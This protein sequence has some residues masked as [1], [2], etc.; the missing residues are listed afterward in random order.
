MATITTDTFL[1]D[2]TART[3]GEA[4]TLNGAKLTVRTDTR[5]HV[6]APAG[7]LGALT[8]VICDGSLGGG[9]FING[10]A[11]RWMAYDTGTGNVPAI[12]TSITQGGV[13]GYL[14]G[15]WASLTSAP[16]A[17]G[18]AM[19][20]T[21]FL[22]FREVT[23][24]QF[25]I[26]ALTGIG[27]NALTTPGSGSGAD[28]PGWIEY[29]QDQGTIINHSHLGSGV[30]ITGEWYTLGT[31]NGS[32]GQT[33][34]IPTNGGGA[35]TWALGVQIETSPGSGVF[36]WWPAVD[37]V[38]GWS[39]SFITTDARARYVEATGG[40][41]IRIGANASATSIGDLP[42]SGCIVRSPNIFMRQTT[43]A[44]RA[45]NVVTSAIPTSRSVMY[46]LGI[47]EMSKVSCDWRNSN[48]TRLAKVRY[49]DCLFESYLNLCDS[50]D[51]IINNCAVAAII[52]P[53]TNTVVFQGCN[54]ISIDGLKAIRRGAGV[55]FAAWHL[56]S[57]TFN[58]ISTA[59]LAMSMSQAVSL[60]GVKNCTLSNVKTVGG[61]ITVRYSS[62]VAVTNLD[63]IERLFG[64]T[65]YSGNQRCVAF[66]D[67]LNCTFSGITFGLN[68][69]LANCHPYVQLFESIGGNTNIK[70]RNAGTRSAP[71][72]VGSIPSL[73]TASIYNNSSTNADSNVYVQRAYLANSRTS[74]VFNASTVGLGSSGA[75]FESTF[76]DTTR[77]LNGAGVW[78]S[79][80]IVK[81]ARGDYTTAVQGPGLHFLDVFTSDTAGRIAFQATPTT[82]ASATFFT[83]SLT[84]PLSG[85]NGTT[86]IMMRTVG[87]YAIIES[88]Y[89]VLG[90]T[91]FANSDATVTGTN[92]E[93]FTYQYQLDTGSGYGG[94]WKTVNGANLSAETI[95][96]TGFKIKLK[97]TVT[98]ANNSNAFSN[99]RTNTVSTSAAQIANLYPLDTNTLTLTGLVAGSEVR[100][101]TGS[102]PA[103]AVEI[104]GTESSGTSFSFSHSAGGV[105]GYIRIFAL[106]YQ[107]VNYDPYTYAAAD[108]SILIQQTV[109]RN[110]V[111]PA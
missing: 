110:Y 16:S 53:T 109:D 49:T 91:A 83:S 17:V 75:L 6:G 37:N 30:I 18:A 24:G 92:T 5:W 85:F 25:A 52:S 86:S 41:L 46:G 102:D 73:Y 56:S 35:A 3:A 106:G 57:G 88:P 43:S 89:W 38:T 77:A 40:G 81:G 44:N 39:T 62:N 15:V 36:E 63:Y 28:A 42:V 14:L 103:T 4:W 27:A 84:S 107:P 105:L 32:R 97:V 51:V 99:L 82:T 79:N 55:G 10:T 108:T 80:S 104:G 23:G 101:Y 19:P 33:F 70:F 95:S 96:P 111:N 12:G 69:A 58:N 93:N 78:P 61:G 66:G 100:C 21:G 50:P 7:M 98:V 74:S 94:T 54:N 31:T 22:K 29:V 9:L 47:H 76:G 68:G 11:V 59:F 72:S 1:D 8:N 20:A 67:S 87:D 90:H 13:S 64:N 65:N 71:L 48:T 34:Q 26:G 60:T 2:G 45:L